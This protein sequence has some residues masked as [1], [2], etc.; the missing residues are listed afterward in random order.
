M[1][2]V[3]I[4]LLTSLLSGCIIREQ[5]PQPPQPK[6]QPKPSPSHSAYYSEIQSNGLT[7]QQNDLLKKMQ[8]DMADQAEQNKQ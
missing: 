4:V 7:Q 6:C 1:R 3:L 2:I 8:K 5:C